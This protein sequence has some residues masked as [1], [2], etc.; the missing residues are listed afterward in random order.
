MDR[1]PERRGGLL[2]WMLC[3]WADWHTVVASMERCCAEF[4]GVD[5]RMRPITRDG[6]VLPA[7]THPSC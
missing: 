4:W 2:V 7:A 1:D 5:S 6:E 3:V